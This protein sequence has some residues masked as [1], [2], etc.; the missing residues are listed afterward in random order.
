MFSL[1]YPPESA[2]LLGPKSKNSEI[3]PV[4]EPTGIVTGRACR[5]HIHDGSLLLHPVTHLHIIN[6]ESKIYLQKRGPGKK[7]LPGCWDTAV[8]GHVSYGEQLEETLYREAREELGFTDFNPVFLGT[9]EYPGYNE[10]EL[11]AVFATITSQTPEPDGVEVTEGRW[12]TDE[13]IAAAPKGTITPNFLQ[14]Y[15]R[16][17][18]TLMALL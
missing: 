13:E 15:A 3:L 2:P 6:R 10:R 9:Y 8:G 18:D 11:V 16:I 14:E 7:L 17:K 12:W 5:N 4:V 1:I